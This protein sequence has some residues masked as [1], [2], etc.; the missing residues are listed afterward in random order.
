MAVLTK[1]SSVFWSHS[2]LGVVTLPDFWSTLHSPN[3]TIHRDIIDTIKGQHVSFRSGASTDADYLI[4]CTGW[5]DHFGLFDEKHKAMLGLPAYDGKPGHA[6]EG[7]EIDWESY[8][9]MADK[10]VDEQLPFLSKP[11]KLQ[12]PAPLDP[13]LQKRWNL[14]RRVIP[15]S[16]AERGDRSLAIL[17][18]IHTIQTPLLSEVQSLWAI[19]Y[20]IGEIDLPDVDTMAKEVSLWNTWTRKRYLN[21][22]QK[23]T[24][25]LYDFLPVS[26]FPA[27]Q[28]ESY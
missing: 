18:Q 20:L 5:G 3:L 9:R 21:Q 8:Y 4:M 12:Y 7:K 17:G 13:A 22:G 15:L 27:L 6:L 24:Y 25:S 26:F 14:Y 11:P 19:L 23:H 16:M 2:G 10:I 1:V 28:N